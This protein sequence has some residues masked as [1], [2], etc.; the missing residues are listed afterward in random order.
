L[1]PDPPE[2]VV[3]PPPVSEQA[4]NSKPVT[5]IARKE[6]MTNLTGDRFR[7]GIVAFVTC[8]DV[9]MGTLLVLQLLHPT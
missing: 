9:F 3:S 4:A 6:W 5:T 7:K 1:P 2:L 8:I